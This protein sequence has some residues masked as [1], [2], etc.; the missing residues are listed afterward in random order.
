M[1]KEGSTYGGC[2][3]FASNA[4]S[5]VLTKMA[6]EEFSI[7]RLAPSYALLL[8]KVNAKPGIQPKELSQIMALT[9][10]TVT[11]LVDKLEQ[12]GLLTR[13]SEGKTMR[14]HPTAKSQ[15][16]N[17]TIQT[18]WTNL[19]QRYKNLLGEETARALTAS[20]YQAT[21]KLDS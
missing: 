2:L 3:Y 4:L 17:A 18:A 21:K 7:A 5:R 20:I 12:K 1:E 15:Q 14:I 9:P 10:S 8:L 13:T 19:Y 16:L 11:R 6:E